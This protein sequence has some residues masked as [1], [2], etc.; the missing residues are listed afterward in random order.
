[1]NEQLRIQATKRIKARRDFWNLVMTFA[2]ITIII[3]AI[4]YFSGYRGYYWP[5][6][7]M[8]GFVIA[9][10][11]TALGTF[12]PKSRPISEEKIEQEMR[13]MQGK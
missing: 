8:L 2:I 5:A 4:W 12:G 3:N 1:M 10:L 7:P 9:L 13:K 6:W 11:F